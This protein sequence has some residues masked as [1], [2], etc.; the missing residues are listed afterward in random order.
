MAVFLAPIIND[1]QENANG[2]PLSGGTIECYL[3]GSSTPVTTYSDKAG[4]VPNTW[5]ITLNT[6][7]VNSQGA[8]WLTGGSTYKY[9][10]KDSTGIVQRTLDNISPLNDT[11]FAVD[12]WVVYQ[13]TPTYVSATSFTLSGDQTQTF[14]L[15]RRVKTTNSG[16]TVY[17]TIKSSTYSAPNTTIT[18]ANDSGALDAGL[19]AVAYS[20]ISSLNSSILPLGSYSAVTSFA[21][22]GA[23]NSANVGNYIIISAASLTITLPTGASVRVG[24]TFT[25]GSNVRFTIARSGADLIAGPATAGATSLQMI[26]FCS[27]VW[28]GD[29]WQIV[30]GG[31]KA[32]ISS[33]G[34]LQFPS[35][36]IKQWG[37]STV[38]LNGS[39]AGAITYPIAF[40]NAPFACS[41][42]LGDNNIL[43]GV[44]LI[45]S[46]FIAASFGFQVSGSP[47]A[48][49]VRISWMAWGY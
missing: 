15:N 13:G 42:V 43:G 32:S 20:I 18:L 10:I 25:F 47:G 44:A 33:P 39:S 27:V 12:Q 11:T 31:D 7:G 35:G 46:Q 6:L 3:A 37:N 36:L 40:P 9:V 2:A 22:N 34:Y 49:S 5:P 30:M 23:L 8:V 16:G 28:R 21:T 29:I 41:P 19:S 17:S 14:S 4:L 24:D 45:N 48:V 38:T 26:G 1:Q